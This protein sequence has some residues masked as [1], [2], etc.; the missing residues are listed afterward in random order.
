MTV[1]ARIVRLWRRMFPERQLLVRSQGKVVLLP[2]S[3]RVQ[4][5]AAMALAVG[6]AGIAYS[7]LANLHS[8]HTIGRLDSQVATITTAYDNLSSRMAA[9][10]EQYSDVAGSMEHGRREIADLRAERDSLR[11]RLRILTTSLERANHELSRSTTE[12]DKLSR[13]LA[14]LQ[15]EL[16]LTEGERGR[17][18]N[19]LDNLTSEL[20][21]TA[22][23]RDAER[24]QREQLAESLV[25]LRHRLEDV[26]TTRTSLQDA[27]AR[28]DRLLSDLTEERDGAKRRQREM[29]QL[30]TELHQQ[31]SA[32]EAA[33]MELESILGGRS[34][35]IAQLRSERDRAREVNSV[36]RQRVANLEGRLTSVR[37][38]QQNILE[39]IRRR[40][41]AG[42]K[43]LEAVV[44][45][46]GLKLEPL[47]DRAGTDGTAIG[48]PL[49][50]LRKAGEAS[51]DAAESDE[52][53][54]AL[55][56]LE[57]RLARWSA[58][59]QILAQ[60]PIVAPV[61]HYRV[62]SVFGRRKD[63]FTK[64][65]AFHSGVDLAGAKHTRVYSTA[66]GTVTFVG[67]RG[68]Y[69]RMVEID[70]GFGL[71]T[72]YG[73]LARIL[74]DKGAKVGHR[75]KIGLMGST[76]RSTG[77]HV[78]YEVLFDGKP[79]NPMKFLE[80]GRHVFKQG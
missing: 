78:H 21:K 31:M 77:I 18:A 58:M 37:E 66:P 5:G 67:R 74:V 54:R 33:R 11:Q 35:Q 46:T 8:T 44:A 39:Q 45:M 49:L 15:S 22:K 70:H 48:G 52:V 30:V 36:L 20:Q 50:S 76:G 72:R 2:L 59:H 12:R 41:D 28:R 6:M 51:G 53:E 17:L 19:N 13:Q 62:S 10:H 23:Q 60:L 1:V 69:G 80:A 73:H 26:E 79:V 43:T 38:S 24:Q 75:Q 14:M 16:Q 68:P 34:G 61:N 57:Q 64:K 32:V 42:I 65:T 40:T 47:L 7:L 27:V 71:T 25:A 3:S 56:S 55:A 29:A 9:V 4:T 63:P